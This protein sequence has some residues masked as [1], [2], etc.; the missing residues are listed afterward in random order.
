MLVSGDLATVN[1]LMK[2][3]NKDDTYGDGDSDGD[4]GGVGDGDDGGVGDGGVV[5]V[6]SL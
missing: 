2:L 5:G 1:Q 3:H 6:V 4:D